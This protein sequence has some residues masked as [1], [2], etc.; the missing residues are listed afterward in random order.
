MFAVL[1]AAVVLLVCMAAGVGSP[2]M[3]GAARAAG[4]CDAVIDAELAFFVDVPGTVD[5][6]MSSEILARLGEQLDAPFAGVRRISLFSTRHR[7]T[8][9]LITV[10]TR[11][12]LFATL[13]GRQW[14]ESALRSRLAG[15]VRAELG[16]TVAPAGSQT[17]TQVLADVSVSTYS[18]SAKNTLVIFSGLREKWRGFDPRR[19]GGVQAAIAAYRMARAGG[20]ER[21]SFK[22]VT[23]HLN[24]IPEPGAGRDVSRCR[25]AFWN[26]YFGDFEG[27]GEGVTWEYLPGSM[28]DAQQLTEKE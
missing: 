7:G 4:S 12:P 25:R 6:S 22:S 14:T 24:V 16:Q 28:S 20:V 19:C 3:S 1:A 11:P 15:A 26:W 23:I 5:E 10:C 8:T 2:A 21:P 13:F 17:L 27:E 18:R 9:P